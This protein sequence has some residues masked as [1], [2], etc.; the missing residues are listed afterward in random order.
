MRTRTGKLGLLILAI[1]SL[2][3]G[4][5]D[6]PQAPPGNCITDTSPGTRT[7]TQA[8]CG[9]DITV[10]VPAM[11][12]ATGCGLVIDAHGFAM[13]AFIQ[14]RNTNLRRLGNS[15]GF[16]VAQPTARVGGQGLPS[17]NIAQ[18]AERLADFALEAIDAFDLDARRIHMTGFSQGAGMTDTNTCNHPEIF[19]SNA[20]IAGRGPNCAGGLPIPVLQTNGTRDEFANFAGAS[21]TRSAIIAAKGM[22]LAQGQVVQ[23]FPGITQTRFAGPGPVYEFIEHNFIGASAGAGHCFPGSFETMLG[24]PPPG[25]PELRFACDD[26]LQLRFSVEVLRFFLANPK[27]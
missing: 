14:D 7:F 5:C 22:T 4:A 8:N 11:C 18:D 25:V 16:V 15:L 17:F 23:S 13:S 9:L 26:P 21:A 2:A 6:M 19:A 10:A 20:P 3:V 12:P 24:G 27:P 1:S